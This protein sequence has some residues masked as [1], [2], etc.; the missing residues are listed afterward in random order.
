[1]LFRY[2]QNNSQRAAAGL[3]G[4]S[5]SV[6]SRELAAAIESLRRFFT[7]HGVTCLRNGFGHSPHHARSA[8]IHWR[9]NRRCHAVIGVGTRGH[10]RGRP[11]LFLALMKTTTTTKI[12]SPPQRHLFS[13]RA[14]FTISRERMFKP[15][16][17]KRLTSQRLPCRGRRFTIHAGVARIPAGLH[18]RASLFAISAEATGPAGLRRGPR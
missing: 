10:V 1:V 5:E 2:F 13:L 18:S 9:R 14:L 12:I 4:C 16:H 6:A 8:G 11:S 7:R 15:S 3:V 17:R